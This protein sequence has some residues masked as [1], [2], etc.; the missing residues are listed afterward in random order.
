M[1]TR[2]SSRSTCER[3]QTERRTSLSELECMIATH[4]PV[5]ESLLLQLPTLS[6][7]SLYH[8][9][10]F[11]RS[12]LQSCPIAWNYISF[13]LP[14]SG[15]TESRQASPASDA[16]AEAPFRQSRQYALDQLLNV[17]V[18]PFGTRLRSL[19]LDNTAA[20]GLT[21]TSTIL[22][23]RRETLQHL[24]VRGCKNVSLKYHILPYLT[25]FSLQK[26]DGHL[27]KASHVDHLALT[28]L[29]TFRCRHHRR[30]PYLPASL[31]RRDSDSEP[32]HELI[33]V[34]HS[35][36]IWS[37]TAW[38]PTPGGRCLRRKDYYTGRGSLDGSGEVWVIFDRLWRSGNRLGLVENNGASAPFL[39][40][41][42]WASSENG[43]EG[44]PLGVSE[45]AGQGEGKTLPAH[46]RRSHRM[47]VENFICHDCRDIIPERCEQ[48]SVTMHCVGCRKTLCASC[49]FSRRL[50]CFKDDSTKD[51]Y[52]PVIRENFWWAPGQIRNPNLMMQE[53]SVDEEIASDQPS[54]SITPA[55]RMYWCCL[56]PLF[57]GGGGITFVGP[58]MSGPSAGQIRAA[59]LPSGRG[60]EDAE[61]S[62]LRLNN[63]LPT[64][65]VGR[66]DTHDFNLKEGHDWMLQWLLYGPN[67]QDSLVCLR[68]LCQECWQTPGWRAQ[69]QVCH[70]P[71]CF[72]HDLRGLKMR[73]C[74]YDLTD[75]KRLMKARF[76]ELPKVPF[77]GDS[78]I[79]FHDC[80]RKFLSLTDALD[81]KHLQELAA[82]ISL[83]Q[84]D[85][86]DLMAASV[87]LSTSSD[88]PETADSA[89]DQE[90]LLLAGTLS[91]SPRPTILETPK[92]ISPIPWRGCASFM[93]QGNRSINDHRPKCT[94]VTK[95]CTACGVHVCQDC[96]LVNPACD[97]SV[98]R[99]AYRCPNCFRNQPQD[100]CKKAEEDERKRQEELEAARRT[101]LAQEMAKLADERTEN[102]RDFLAL[103]ELE[104][105]EPGETARA[106]QSL[107]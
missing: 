101:E 50:P 77:L 14:S 16:S 13:R 49:A 15:R 70:E 78:E 106:Q 93:C 30:R 18:V 72:A 33:K 63:D 25:L 58:G 31:I 94:A 69:C 44:E 32:T 74:G 28:S 1:K 102:A 88:Q 80:I 17:V 40:G 86:G 73:V 48:C 4:A 5:H 52:K 89:H 7:L 103:F 59:P 27:N 26:D 51:V 19:D 83:P 20:S 35:L 45:V 85:D 95:R 97:C 46:L 87:D 8:T 66:L 91:S 76:P 11:L 47:F 75:E 43:Y 107:G 64:G 92:C 10:Q 81:A 56:K 57:S 84:T 36:G 29:Y 24:S 104:T 60:W 22:P 41:Q 42:L 2:C 98:C 12:F 79:K 62:Q 55:I 61:F 39:K 71:C 90:E 38:C 65:A 53:L 3:V 9:S 6:I 21:L 96:L 34:C 100:L 82:L 105:F 37:D 68:S 54:S 67:S 23:A 99:D